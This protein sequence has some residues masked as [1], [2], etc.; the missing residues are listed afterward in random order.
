MLMRLEK[1]NIFGRE[2]QRR[3]QNAASHSRDEGNHLTRKMAGFSEDRV[4]APLK[5]GSVMLVANK[6]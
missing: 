3:A 4:A 2:R 6:R 5:I 1:F